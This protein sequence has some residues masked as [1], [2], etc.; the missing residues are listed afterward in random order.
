MRRTSSWPRSARPTRKREPHEYDPYRG[1]RQVRQADV[2]HS[3]HLGRQT[4]APSCRYE[5]RALTAS[6][7]DLDAH[8]VRVWALPRGPGT[9]NALSPGSS[10][11]ARTD[12]LRTAL[13]EREERD[14]A[15]PKGLCRICGGVAH[16]GEGRVDPP[17][18]LVGA[19]ER[20]DHEFQMRSVPPEVMEWRRVC[21]VC[22]RADREGTLGRMIIATVLGIA[23][24]EAEAA[25]VAGSLVRWD[26]G[27][28]DFA[29]GVTAVAHGQAT[30]RA[31]AH[32]SDADIATMKAAV[33]AIAREGVPTVCNWGACGM[34]GIRYATGW[35]ESSLTWPDGS[36]APVCGHCAIV[37]D[38][39]GWPS[40]TAGIRRVACEAATGVPIQLGAEAPP[41]FR[42][43]AE[44]RSADGNG[45]ELAWDYSEGVTAWRES[46]WESYPECA[47]VDRRVE[48]E[49]RHEQRDHERSMLY[50]E[51]QESIAASG[52]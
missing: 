7:S 29:G 52:W 50:R 20:A 34:C 19:R 28:Q 16:K 42:Y 48:F 15:M 10:M 22:D 8:A 2:D 45:H 41:D 30:G 38:L 49:N 18:T 9:C 14:R 23:L 13:R 39:R 21:G 37:M 11:S 5:L 1:L 51:E 12:R 32:L 27:G 26:A 40:D 6:G 35:R 43:Y 4:V 3:R 24:T 44:R 46:V 33:A 17:P 47:P 36:H 31:W 25:R